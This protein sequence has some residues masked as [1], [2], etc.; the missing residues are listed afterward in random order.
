MRVIVRNACGGIGFKEGISG[1][2]IGSI[3]EVPKALLYVMSSTV[4]RVRERERETRETREA[5]VLELVLCK[6]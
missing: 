3:D 5:C 4:E 2:V 1:G 6:K